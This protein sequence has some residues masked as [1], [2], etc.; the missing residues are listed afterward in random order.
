MSATQQSRPDLGRQPK[1]VR[2]AVILM[3]VAAAVTVLEIIGEFSELSG[4]RAQ[5]QPAG[6][7]PTGI[8]VTSRVDALASLLIVGGLIKAGSW[9][10]IALVCRRGRGWGRIAATIFFGAGCIAFGAGCL[11]V[12]YTTELTTSSGLQAL[13]ALPILIGLVVVIMLWSEQSGPHFRTVPI[14]GPTEPAS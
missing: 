7:D 9:L 13:D 12:A 3:V 6:G 10:W 2:Y 14:A 11:A 1:P 8:L 5:L 4:N